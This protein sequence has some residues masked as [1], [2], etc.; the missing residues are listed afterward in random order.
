LVGGN[1]SAY[2]GATANKLIRLH[3]DGSRDASLSVLTIGDDDSDVFAIAEQSNGRIIV[4]GDFESYDGSTVNNIVRL[5]ASGSR[6]TSF[7]MGDGFDGTVYAIAVQ[8]NGKIL[9]GGNF[10]SYNGDTAN[11]IVRLNSD[12]TKDTSFDMGDGFDGIVRT[13]TIQNNGKILIGG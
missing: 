1:F 2:K 4:G 10:T 5:T 9:V 7:D 3:S 13:I 8:N 11:N 6:D 12:G